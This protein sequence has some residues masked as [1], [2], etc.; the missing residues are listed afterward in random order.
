MKSMI[1]RLTGLVLGLA[2]IATA[3]G[4]SNDEGASE[5]S[6][7]RIGPEVSPVQ[8]ASGPADELA[9][10]EGP[11]YAYFGDLHVHT[12]YSMDAFQFGTLAT[13]DDAYRFAQGEAIK[14]PGGFD[15]Q[16]E[17]PL[18]FYAV[19]DHGIFLGVVRAGADT[20]TDISRYPAMQSIHNLNAAENLTLESVPTRNF[21]A[22]IGQFRR[23]MA[24]SQPLL[25]EV[26][27]VMRST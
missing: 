18:D 1:K 3:G 25:A 22:W 16:L 8:E 9:A 10:F 23:A 17:R 12:A 4:C 24:G 27:R 14:H 21:R 15:M 2:L 6:T 20:S 13:P 26:A 11:R 7:A 5:K 19:T